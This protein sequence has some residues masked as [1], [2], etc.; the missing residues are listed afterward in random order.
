MGVSAFGALV[1][2]VLAATPQAD[3]SLRAESRSTRVTVAGASDVREAAT[4]QPRLDAWLDGDGLRLSGRYQPRIWTSDVATDPAPL[5][6]H[7]ASAAL[8][9][10]GPSRWQGSLTSTATRGK[11]DPLAD[12]LAAATAPAAGATGQLASTRPLEYE[13]LS[14]AGRGAMLLSQRTTLA[15]G[16]SWG[17]SR[18]ANAEARQVLPPQRVAVATAAASYLA[19]PRDTL[20][21]GADGSWSVTS[22][23]LGALTAAYGTAAATWR[24]R[25]TLTLDGWAGAGGSVTSE[26]TAGQPAVLRALPFGQAGFGRAA[27]EAHLGFQVAVRLTP[28]FDRVD[29]RVRSTADASATLAW[30][31]RRALALST[32]ATGAWRT[33]GDTSFG[34]WEAR[35]TW[36]ARER[37]TVE[38]GLIA[39]WQRDRRPGIPSFV[40]TGAIAA[41]SYGAGTAPR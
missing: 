24:R 26:R 21:L 14:V 23:A 17:L 33:D 29:G 6:E 15:G 28:A 13:A 5:L 9:T 40:E 12:A 30:T 16:A 1:S 39:R 32:T 31:P 7:S 2:F 8:E 3:A 4:I 22:A 18:G 37:L 34:A 27:D 19:S 35:A 36:A 11:T 38:L 25:L 10:R 41:V 20:Q